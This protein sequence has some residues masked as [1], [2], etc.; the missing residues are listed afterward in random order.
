MK[1]VQAVAHQTL[2][3][4]RYARLVRYRRMRIRTARPRLSGIF[5]TLP[6]HVK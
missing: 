4:I 6:V 1:R 2:R 3:K 5:P